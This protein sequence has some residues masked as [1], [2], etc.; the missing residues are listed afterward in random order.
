[1]ILPTLCQIYSQIEQRNLSHSLSVVLC[2]MYL[3]KFQYVSFPMLT[4]SLLA[5]GAAGEAEDLDA[6]CDADLLLSRRGLWGPDFLLVLPP[7]AE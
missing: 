5:V 4:C 6:C 3:C 1:M 7:A 2:I